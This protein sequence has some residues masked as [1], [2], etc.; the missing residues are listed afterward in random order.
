MSPWLYRFGKSKLV[1]SAFAAR[2]GRLD[3]TLQCCVSPIGNLGI[4]SVR[5]R[6]RHSELLCDSSMSGWIVWL[7]SYLGAVCSGVLV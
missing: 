6:A 5:I 1:T 4:S 7:H 2:V 3:W